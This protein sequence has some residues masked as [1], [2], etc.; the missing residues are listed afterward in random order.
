MG[1]GHEKRKIFIGIKDGK[2]QRKM[3]DG[4]REAFDFIE[5]ELVGISAPDVEMNFGTAKML[6]LEIRDR[7]TGEVYTLGTSLHGSVGRSVLNSLSSAS[8]LGLLHI[9]PYLNKA[10]FNAVFITNDGAKLSWLAAFPEKKCDSQGNEDDA[11][12]RAFTEELFRKV[13]D[14]VYHTGGGPNG[15]PV[16][17]DDDVPF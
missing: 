1:L 8:A 2:V 3:D 16:I 7:E 6:Q 4:S 12:R 11:D 15:N 14:V 9:R 5:G 10:G 17:T 13:K